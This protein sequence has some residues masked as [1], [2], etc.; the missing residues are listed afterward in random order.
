MS[1]PEGRIAG[2]L[3]QRMTNGRMSLFI[4]DHKEDDIGN[5]RG[6]Q[7]NESDDREPPT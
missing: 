2:E 4:V 3:L 1:S 7:Q 6:Y 5:I